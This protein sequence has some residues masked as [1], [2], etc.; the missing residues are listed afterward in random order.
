MRSC[1]LASNFVARRT[2]LASSTMWM[3]K[4]FNGTAAPGAEGEAAASSTAEK[5]PKEVELES[6]VESLTKQ[7]DEKIAE[8]NEMKKAATYALAEAENARRVA[9]LDIDK[10]KDY[11]VTAIAKDMLEVSDTLARAVEAFHKLDK[12]TEKNASHVLT[13]VKMSLN[14]LN[15]NLG[16]HNIEKI[17]AAKG[18]KF[19]PSVH[20]A[21]CNAP[22][23]EETPADTIAFVVKEGYKIKDRVLRAAQVAVAKA[24]E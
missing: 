22:A 6:K 3:P 10:A 24:Q 12:E 9:K 21:I 1:R 11:S 16:R 18:T 5:S 4:R 17:P 15:H 2:V 19:D 8:V 14:V 20:D 23:T 7:L 13:G